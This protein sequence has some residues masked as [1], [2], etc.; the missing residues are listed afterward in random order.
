MVSSVTANSHPAPERGRMQANA[1]SPYA[2][3]DLHQAIDLIDRKIAYGRILETFESEE[4][5]EI[6][7]RKLSSKRA[8]LVR[9]ALALT[10]QGVRCDPRFLPR[11]FIHPVQGEADS[12]AASPTVAA[13]TKGRIPPRRRQKRS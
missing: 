12:V 8:A 10:A 2:L 3:K 13:A 11:S 6:H 4:A 1:Y 7:L 5:R 9:S